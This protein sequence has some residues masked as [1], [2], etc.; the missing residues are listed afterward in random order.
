[1]RIL[2]KIFV[3]DF[4]RVHFGFFLFTALIL[5]GVGNPGQ[6]LTFHLGVIHAI[7][8]N[9]F[10][11]ITT[12]V[13]WLLYLLKSLFFIREKLKEEAQQ[14]LFYSF[15][16][17]NKIT[18]I[19][20]WFFT[21]ALLNI[22]ILLYA[23]IC[24]IVGFYTR[25]IVIALLLML[26]ML[27][28]IS[29]GSF[30][31]DRFFYKRMTTQTVQ[32]NNYGLIDSLPITYTFIGIKYLLAEQKLVY[33][34][35][36]LCSY[37]LIVAMYHIFHDL[38]DNIALAAIIVTSLAT[39]HIVLLFGQ[40]RFESQSLALLRNLPYTYNFRFYATLKRNFLLFIPEIIWLFFRFEIFAS[41]ILIIYMLSLSIFLYQSIS[42]VGLKLVSYVKF[43]F[44]FFLLL[45][46]T[47]PLGYLTITSILL[48]FCAWVIFRLKPKGIS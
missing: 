20:C 12:M 36:K 13:F 38:Q 4:Y 9:S 15:S 45:V 31:M 48:F 16:S 32:S 41:S 28:F 42:L 5:F 30:L 46:I 2:Y 39:A 23:I 11:L 21:L 6:L 33:G 37:L 8:T 7:L 43:T 22:P 25:N 1:M 3:V 14:F 40:F 18:R 34:I 17:F 35:C 24:T 47:L 27:T 44:F 26:V 10:A 29:V 19:T